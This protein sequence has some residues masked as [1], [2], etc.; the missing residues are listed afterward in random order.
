MILRGQT[1]T[2]CVSNRDQ[3]NGEE[4]TPRQLECLSWTQEGKSA[5]D[6]GQILGISP[7]TVETHLERVCQQFGVRT[8]V[9]AVVKAKDLGLLDRANGPARRVVGKLTD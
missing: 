5:T 1:S 2:D 6:I 8:R 9:Q 3:R 4:P 7:R